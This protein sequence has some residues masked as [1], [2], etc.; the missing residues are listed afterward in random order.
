M[1]WIL[2]AIFMKEGRVALMSQGGG[3]WTDLSRWQQWKAAWY[4]GP[5]ELWHVLGLIDPTAFL[6]SLFL[7]GLTIL[8][9]VIRWRMVLRVQGLDLRFSRAMEISLIAIS[10]TPSCS[11][12]PE[13]TC[14]RLTM[15]R[16]KRIIKKLKRW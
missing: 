9:G 11:V 14:S 10:L 15:L 4:Y 1:L 16:A 12:P 3:L 5:R 2:H 7:M 8:L 6:T 13:A